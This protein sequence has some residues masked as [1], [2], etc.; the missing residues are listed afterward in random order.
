MHRLAVVGLLCGLAMVTTSGC[1]SD[2]PQGPAP[3][4][5]GYPLVYSQSFDEGVFMDWNLSNPRAWRIE[6]FDG[7]PVLSL[8]QRQTSYVPPV[9]SPQSRAIRGD[10]VVSD[11]VLEAKLR[12]TAPTYPQRDL[13]VFFGYQD[14]THYYYAHLA[15]EA[16]EM[17]HNVFLVNGADRVPIG[18]RRT[19]GLAWGQRWHTVRVVRTVATGA[20]SVFVDDM[21]TPVLAANDTT[22]AQGKIGI[23]SFD[24]IGVFDDIYVW[25]ISADS[26]AN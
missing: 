3:S 17:E 22:F 2:E 18:F 21:T 1:S 15:Q 5:Q 13:A 24:D 8:F 11:F 14:E 6:R 19:E 20:I 10:L 23:G 16:S 25:G 9:V 7:N 4:M 26:L 12:T